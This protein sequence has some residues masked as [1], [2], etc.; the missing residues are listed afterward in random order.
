MLK[1]RTYESESF[2]CKIESYSSLASHTASWFSSHHVER[3]VYN[4]ELIHIK[5]T[6]RLP[7]SLEF[8]ITPLENKS[9]FYIER[10][11]SRFH[12]DQTILCS[13][14]QVLLSWQLSDCGF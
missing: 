7:C 11:A 6:I 9:R 4:L 13:S 8:A 5:G 3:R 1:Q 2:P 12:V 10:I 14:R